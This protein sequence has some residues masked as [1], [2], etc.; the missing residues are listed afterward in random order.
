MPFRVGDQVRLKA[1]P[2]TQGSVIAVKENQSA[3]GG[4]QWESW[5]GKFHT[6]KDSEL[7][8]SEGVG[9]FFS[10]QG[11]NAYEIALNAIAMSAATKVSG[12]GFWNSEVKVFILEDVLCEVFLS[13]WL[14]DAG[15]T[16]FEPKYPLSE[17][18]F[19]FFF[20][21]GEELKSAS[22]KWLSLTIA[23]TAYRMLYKMPQFN[24]GR[25]MYALRTF[26]GVAG[27]NALEKGFTKREVAVYRPK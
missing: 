7:E 15:I 21:T 26:I 6:N 20:P 22:N 13:K 5:T 14:K 25:M 19:S 11:P 23:D 8:K 27:G 16:I 18:Q 12:L 9:A 24:T 17:E 4:V 1:E 2:K 3:E 10:A